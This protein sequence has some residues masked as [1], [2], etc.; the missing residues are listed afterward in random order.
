MTNFFV[1]DTEGTGVQPRYD[2]PFQFAR[3]IY[4]QHGTLLRTTNLRGRLPLYVL[5]DPEAL[6][7]T[8][9]SIKNIQSAP[10]SHYEFVERV[11][12]D[13][14]ANSPATVMSYN[15]IRYDEEI[16]RHTFYANLRAPY[17][18]QLAGNER[19]DVLVVAKA[20]AGIARDA[21]DIPKGDDDKPSFKLKGLA[22]ANGFTDHN[23]HD[24]LGD[25]EATMHLAQFMKSHAG[26]IWEACSRN[27]SKD[28]VL[29]L[30]KA[31]K[32][33]VLVGWSHEVGHPH[34]QL[35]QPVT[36]DERNAN[37]W[38][39][40]DLESDVDT[41]LELSPTDLAQ[42]FKPNLGLSTALRI[43]VNAL[44]MVF[45][46]ETAAYIGV[47]VP[48]EFRAAERV[49]ADPS[50]SSRLRAAATIYKQ[51]PEQP[52][53]IWNQLY[54]GCFFPS[55]A[56]KGV[57]EKFHQAHPSVKWDLISD[58]TDHRARHMARWLVGSEW[59]E[60][61]A[62][63][64]RLS[65]EEEFRS[66]LMNQKGGWTSIPSAL[67]RIEEL[68]PKTSLFQ[69]HILDQYQAYLKSLRDDLIM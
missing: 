66:H 42:K 31:G 33:L 40:V 58:M 17:V 63:V 43:K 67:A 59:P 61:L 32:P 49:L 35:I 64:D 34:Y 4:D 8:G 50:F 6:L 27:Q 7:V 62:S 21:L 30:M 24:A 53:D 9:Q 23:A 56:D 60:I 44:P 52:K 18:T 12:A 26:R 38:L 54:G 11:H 39:C 37:E 16:L 36:T 51:N 22:A 3:C 2:R 29:G 1:Y 57:L 19:L 10:L 55:S 5:P 25:V 68:R 15:G 41:M 28:H 48:Y 47:E 45:S 65:I 46:I 69:I 14:V 20:V 13:I